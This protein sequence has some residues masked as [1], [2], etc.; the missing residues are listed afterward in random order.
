M[1]MSIDRNDAASVRDTGGPGAPRRHSTTQILRAA[2]SVF[3]RNGFGG[4]SMA[5]IAEAAELPKANLHYYF[6]NKEA[7]YCAVLEDILSTWLADA[8]LWITPERSAREGL[9]GYIR[10]KM[11]WTRSRADASR[12]FAGEMLAGGAR[13]RHFLEGELRDYVARIGAVFAIWV[14]NGSMR[15][16]SA[17]HLL[18]CIWA[19]TQSY[20][21][22]APQMDA[23]LGRPS[24]LGPDDYG[25]GCDTILTLVLGGT[26]T[27]KA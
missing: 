1:G 15:P 20:A 6:G 17:E 16:V 11:Q 22:F 27:E 21:D 19:M 7:L 14:A 4:S 3:A 5:A 8:D 12:I 10:A 24:G 18:F 23:V 25:L 9:E 13:I 2:E 26:A